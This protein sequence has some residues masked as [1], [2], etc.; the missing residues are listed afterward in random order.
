[1][2]IFQFKNGTLGNLSLTEIAQSEEL[3]LYV[4][5]DRSLGDYVFYGR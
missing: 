3:V 2:V 5:W 1:M 4:A